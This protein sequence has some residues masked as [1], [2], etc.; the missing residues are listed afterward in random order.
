V[1]VQKLEHNIATLQNALDALHL[2]LQGH[3]LP[4]LDFIL[5]EEFVVISDEE[6]ECHLAHL[7]LDQILQNHFNVGNN[8][9]DILLTNTKQTTIIDY[10]QIHIKD[11]LE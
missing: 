2:K 7:K 4:V 3:Q 11:H 9:R 1:Q 5:V 10:L 6:G 8:I